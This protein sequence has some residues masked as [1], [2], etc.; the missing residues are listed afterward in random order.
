MRRCQEPFSPNG[1]QSSVAGTVSPRKQF[2]PPSL[3]ALWGVLDK[4]DVLW[5][6]WE[7]YLRETPL[8]EHVKALPR[9]VMWYAD[10]AGRTEI[11]ELRAADL[12]VLRGN[13]D[14][15]IGIQAVRARMQTGRLKVLSSHCPNL[16]AE[17]RLYRYPS[18]QEKPI[19]GENPI[20]DNNHA[21]G[22]LRYL[23]TRLDHKFVAKLRRRQTTE[24]AAGD[25]PPALL[26]PTETAEAVHQAR[27]WLR[28]DNETLWKKL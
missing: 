23:I 12:K 15:R 14:I 3:H 5:I 28:F 20:D 19:L 25:P 18:A 27:P 24:S 6:G 21:L 11:E 10:P 9:N 8:H 22:A 4:E 1:G 26:D 13:N 2:L 7:R 16:I 17:A